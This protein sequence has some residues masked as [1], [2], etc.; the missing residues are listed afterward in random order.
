[1]II[2]HNKYIPNS[3]INVYFSACDAVV[4]PYKKISQSGIIPMAYHFDKL[5][6]CSDILSLKEHIVEKKTGYLFE[7]QNPKS[8]CKA[9][10]EIC[11]K[12][13]FDKT[14]NFISIYKKKFTID[15]LAD[16]IISF[17]E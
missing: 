11:Y 7:N 6:I 8:L 9:L 15:K 3:D 4:L 16:D 1:M 10:I 13:N 2:W 17:I 12:H 5:V 14:D